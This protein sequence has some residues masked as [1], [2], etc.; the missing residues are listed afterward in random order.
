MD[1]MCVSLQRYTAGEHCIV[2]IFQASTMKLMES[3]QG[4]P[5]GSRPKKTF[6][7][8]LV[9]NSLHCRQPAHLSGVCKQITC[10]NFI[11]QVSL[12][13]FI[14]TVMLIETVDSNIVVGNEQKEVNL[15]EYL[16]ADGK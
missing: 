10:N 7:A 4:I 1:L 13:F 14:F 9:S 2:K 8:K 3:H 16:D 12:C 6:A 11:Y 5:H 15:G